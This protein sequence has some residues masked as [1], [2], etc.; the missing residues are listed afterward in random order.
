MPR[1]SALCALSLLFALAAPPLAA[2]TRGE[3]VD[4]ALCRII[5]AAARGADLPEDFLT[6]LIWREST[7]RPHVVSPKGARGI[8]QFMPGTAAERGLA[9]PFDPETALPAAA[10]LLKELRTRFGNLGL[11]AAAYNAGPGRVEGFLAGRSGLP[12]ETRFYVRAITGRSAEEWAGDRTKPG[13]GTAAPDASGVD[14]PQ[15]EAPPADCPTIVAALRRGAPAG[16]AARGADFAPW[17]VQVAGAFSK[18]AAL[19]AYRRAG[20]RI[21]GL[22]GDSTPMIIG[23]RLAGRGPRPFYR[24]RL[25]AETRSAA[26]ALCQRIRAAGGAC[27]VLAN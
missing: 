19:E 11:A 25:P 26:N 2:Q 15:P 5:A 13:A 23:T 8:A 6:R 12:G 4:A 7:F 3:S 24:V 27:I 18:N 20:V 21:A 22:V 14:R 16:E 9:D 1:R 10:H 17:G